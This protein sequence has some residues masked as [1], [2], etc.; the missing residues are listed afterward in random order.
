MQWLVTLC[1]W[2]R[3]EVDWSCF[4]DTILLLHMLRRSDAKMHDWIAPL[5]R[6]PCHA[7]WKIFIFV[8]RRWKQ[9]FQGAKVWIKEILN[10]VLE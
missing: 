10:T 5:V 8:I 3:A 9:L 4:P 1:I 7:M 2:G 6:D